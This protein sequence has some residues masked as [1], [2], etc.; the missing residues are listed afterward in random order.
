MISPI[1]EYVERQ[2]FEDRHDPEP[3]WPDDDDWQEDE[4]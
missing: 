2:A 3:I 4:S 1:P